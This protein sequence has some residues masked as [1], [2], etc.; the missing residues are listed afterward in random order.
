MKRLLL[1]LSLAG[2]STVIF[3]SG[4]TKK[5]KDGENTLNMVVSANIKGL[6]PAQASDT[7]SNLVVS[8]VFEGLLHYNYLKRPLQLE[9][10]IAA[11][12]PKVSK[13]GLT[14]TFKIRP[15]LRFEDNVVFPDGKGREITAE[16]FI[17][18]W[19]RI[20]DPE[21]QSEG[22]W[23]FDGKIKGLNEWREK[24]AK[25]EADYKTPIEGLQAPDAHTLVIK[26]TKPYYQLHYVLAMSYAS[27]VPKEAVEK[28]GKE[29]LNH[30]VGS[31][32]FK[33][34]SWTRNSQ[35]VLVR[36]TNWSTQNYPSEGEE[37]DKTNGNL[38]DAGQKIPFVD[39]VIIQEITE[40]QPRWLN[41]MKGNL[42]I[43]SIPKDN[44][45]SAVQNDKV[46]DELAKK[47]IKLM[48]SREPDLTY[49]AFN[50]LDP[51]V[52]KNENLRKAIA[53]AMDVET[54]IQ[55]FYNGRAI[56][57]QSPI[58][59][60]V[61]GYDPQ[62]KHP[63][64]GYDLSKAKEFLAK[65]GFPEGKGLAPIEYSTTNSSTARQMAE[66]FKQNMEAIK[67]PV[68]I[69]TSSWPQFT[70][71]IREKK[72]QIWGIAWLAD[73]PDAENFFQ[74]LYGPNV[75]PGP[76]NANYK[77]KSYDE[78]YEKASR[79]PP[80]PARTKIYHQMRDLVVKD[81]PWIVDAHRLGYLTHHGWVK[82]LKY[83]SIVND[84]FKY[85]KV[86]TKSRAELKAKF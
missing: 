37:A 32:P 57:A 65:A 1:L 18:S 56:A 74:L 85:L 70:T 16:D 81:M 21:I 7:Y 4:C 86:D 34:E 68:N 31:G 10:L 53:H 42:D 77:S 76:N 58:P 39:K 8:Q 13:D 15:G 17:F 47:G 82:N 41:F 3:L 64:Q 60:D 45:D 20:A 12:M 59:P 55:K 79:L 48:I 69:V 71:K 78:L 23:I 33:F 51:V 5:N 24:L 2:F 22:F 14:H 30:P 83:H 52:G 11:E 9:P 62:F 27:V 75:S 46:S 29:F 43:V 44:F 36:N 80:G 73:Y 40:D 49:T 35:V 67:I 26:L 25:K 72:A 66:F 28:Y 6:D 61:D 50:M 84:Y 54:L 19:R 63:N 38:A